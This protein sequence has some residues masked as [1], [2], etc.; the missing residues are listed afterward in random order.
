[1]SA[2]YKIEGVHK[3]EILSHIHVCLADSFDWVVRAEVYTE[4]S[5]VV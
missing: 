1:M 2:Y 3:I 4:Q 5:I